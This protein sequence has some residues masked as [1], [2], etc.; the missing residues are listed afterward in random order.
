M[1]APEEVGGSC[2]AV[3]ASWTPRSSPGL[4]CEP[5]LTNAA[6]PTT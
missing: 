3:L 1:A 6:S 5:V 2:L 4:P